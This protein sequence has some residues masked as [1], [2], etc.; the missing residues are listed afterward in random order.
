MSIMIQLKYDTT[1]KK[2]KGM[3][4]GSCPLLELQLDTLV[5][6]DCRSARREQQID[7]NQCVKLFQNSCLSRPAPG[8]SAGLVSGFHQ[9][10]KEKALNDSHPQNPHPP[11]PECA[12]SGSPSFQHPKQLCGCWEGSTDAGRCADGHCPSILSLPRCFF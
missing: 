8:G 7:G 9:P 11:R 2:N 3:V 12:G 1:I 10:M 5:G 4:E 6:R